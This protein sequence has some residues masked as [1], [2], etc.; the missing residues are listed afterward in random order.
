[1]TVKAYTPDDLEFLEAT[2]R[3]F[4]AGKELTSVTHAMEVVGITDYSSVPFDILT[5]AQLIGDYAHEVAKLYALRDLD[6]PALDPQLVGFL[7][8]IKKFFAERVQMVINV[9][10]KV[11]D[12]TLGYAGRLDIVYLDYSNTVCLDDYKTAKYAHP[13]ARLQTAA[14]KR[15]Y[16][17]IYNVRVG[18]RAG[19]YLDGAGG[20]ERIVHKDPHD[21][22]HF[23]SALDTARWKESNKLWRAAA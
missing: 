10:A 17:R 7:D 11:W 19:V 5:R 1:M 21:F 4:L 15:P 8:S 13:A 18:E 16:E 22:H 3:Y 6:E 9:E 23:A 2:H 20:Y 14:Y 12:L